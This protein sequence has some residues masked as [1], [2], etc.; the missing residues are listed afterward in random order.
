RKNTSC[1]VRI[2]Q[3]T[4]SP[5]LSLETKSQVE[6]ESSLEPQEDVSAGADRLSPGS[7]LLSP[8]SLSSSSP[9]SCGGS[10]CDRSSDCDFWRPPSPSSSPDSGKCSTP[11]AED[12]HHFNIPLFPYSWSAYSGSELRHLVQGQY[13]HH[14]R[15]QGHREPHSPVSIYGAEDS[16]TEP[17][18]AQRGPAAGCYQDY[19]STAQQIRRMR[20]AEQLYVDVKHKPRG[21]EIKSENDFIC[22]N[23]ESSGSYKCIKCCKVRFSV[24]VSKIIAAEFAVMLLILLTF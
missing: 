17:L 23:F 2:S 6:F 5:L 15:L 16:G 21:A 12:G 1:T 22:S 13:H 7:R 3:F 8:G 9:L 24:L 11:A 18:Y 10:V 20:D 14:Q 19:S 4:R